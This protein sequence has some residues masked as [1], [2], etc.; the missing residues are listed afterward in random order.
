[1]DQRT[2]HVHPS[3]T[4]TEQDQTIK[5]LHQPP[6]R[7]IEAKGRA[8]SIQR[9]RPPATQAS[10]EASART[11][12]ASTGFMCRPSGMRLTARMS[13]REYLIRRPSCF[14]RPKIC[15]TASSMSCYC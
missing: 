10:M 15:S 13:A 12:S 9:T 6:H 14:G 5:S 7:W 1:M 8:G 4:V 3:E 2:G 11:H